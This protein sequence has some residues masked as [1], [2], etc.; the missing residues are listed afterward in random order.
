M[1]VGLALVVFAVDVGEVVEADVDDFVVA[2]VVLTVVVETVVKDAFVVAFSE[3]GGDDVEF[4]EG[5]DGFVVVIVVVDVV[6]DVVLDVAAAAVVLVIL[7]C[8]P[9]GACGVVLTGSGDAGC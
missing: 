3:A 6:V 9:C 4:P 8:D 1:D 2:I 5:G 7:F